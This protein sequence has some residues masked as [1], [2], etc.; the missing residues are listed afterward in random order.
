MKVSNEVRHGAYVIQL[1]PR[2]PNGAHAW[3]AELRVARVADGGTRPAL[4]RAGRLP[5]ARR[6]G[7]GRGPARARSHLMIVKGLMFSRQVYLGK[8]RY[9]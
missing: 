7:R 6:G 1:T 5:D 9:T 2:Q 3:L 8:P 4:Q